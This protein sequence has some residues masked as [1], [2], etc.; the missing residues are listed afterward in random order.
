M[1][2]SYH[3][4]LS[5]FYMSIHEGIVKPKRDKATAISDIQRNFLCNHPRCSLALRAN[6]DHVR[7]NIISEPV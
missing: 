3:I 4:E 5:Q 6:K 2:I 7:Q 1:K